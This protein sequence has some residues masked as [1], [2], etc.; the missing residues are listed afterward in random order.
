[1]IYY[2]AKP[3]TW[4][5]AGTTVKLIDFHYELTGDKVGLFEGTR[6]CENPASE[7]DWKTVGQEYTD[8]EVC[9]Y[10][11]FEEIEE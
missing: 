2:I 11:E 4:F 7:G 5:K 6:V 9:F 10:D 3:N 8:Q 1:M